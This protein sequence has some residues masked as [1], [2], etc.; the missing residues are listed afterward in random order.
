MEGQV[1]M[2]KINNESLIKKRTLKIAVF[3]G[4]LFFILYIII[5]IV[6]FF[7]VLPGE[8][9]ELNNNIDLMYKFGSPMSEY[10]LDKSQLTRGGGGYYID[11]EDGDYYEFSGYPDVSNEYKF[12]CFRTT[13]SAVSVF[14]VNVGNDI[15]D[16]MRK[17]YGYGYE[18]KVE[19]YFSDSYF[20]KGKVRIRINGSETVES[21]QVEL[22]NTNWL[23]KQF[24]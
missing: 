16:V 24:K 7:T 15:Y 8:V 22:I 12:T 14:G 2:G 17:L 19:L 1:L 9:K 5:K 11:N 4:I 6:M 21:I 13:N 20:I 18:K 3:M 10:N 23:M